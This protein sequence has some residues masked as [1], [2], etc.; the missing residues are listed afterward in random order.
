MPEGIELGVLYQNLNALSTGLNNNNNSNNISRILIKIIAT[1]LPPK[2]ATTWNIVAY[3][4][5]SLDA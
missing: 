2:A 1:R 4:A 3:K 5:E